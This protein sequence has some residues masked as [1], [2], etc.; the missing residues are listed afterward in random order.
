ME[1]VVDNPEV[2]DY[3]FGFGSFLMGRG[4]HLSE[5][6][7]DQIKR[8]IEEGKT[9]REIIMITGCSYSYIG[10]VKRRMNNLQEINKTKKTPAWKTKFFDEWEKAVRKIMY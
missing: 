6:L 8:C 9:Y 4:I 2:K 7:F 5:L 1:K 3:L 10:M